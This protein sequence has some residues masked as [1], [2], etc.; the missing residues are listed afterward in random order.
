MSNLSLSAASD[1]TGAFF[2]REAGIIMTVAFATFG[3]GLLMVELL[4]PA[5]DASSTVEPGAWMLWL[6]PAGLLGILGQL[7]ISLLVL[8]PG[9]SV[10]EALGGALRRLPVVLAVI[11]L[12]AA[13]AG[14]AVTLF[15]LLGGLAA[16]AAGAGIEGASVFVMLMLALFFLWG[17]SRLFLIWPLIADHVSGPVGAIR[18]A[19][20][21]S[22]GHGWRFLSVILAFSIVY[23]VSIGAGRVGFGS[24]FLILGKLIG[25]E[26]IA[27]FL[28]ALA[29]ALIGTLLQA[30]WAVFVTQ[31]YRR[32]AVSS[33]G[34]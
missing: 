24:L 13:A 10:R 22:R 34:I 29:V 3:L 17:T 23:L 9:S 12:L 18:Q 19:W 8:T 2:R 11:L 21:L 15:S 1:E 30:I 6:I 25:S 5:P 32:V 4:T 28:A 14:A 7:T 33:N 26:G 31:L 16:V 20:G 27:R